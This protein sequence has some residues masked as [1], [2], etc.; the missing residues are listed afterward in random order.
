MG[1]VDLKLIARALEPKGFHAQ[2]SDGDLYLVRR[3]LEAEV[4]ERVVP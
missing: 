2:P 4:Y 1:A 3:S